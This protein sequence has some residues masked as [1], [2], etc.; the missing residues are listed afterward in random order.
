[1]AMEFSPPE[2]YKILVMAAPTGHLTLARAIISYLEDLPGVQIHTIDLV[3]GNFEWK[4]FRF[5][6]RYTP[7]MMGLFFMIG[8]V[9]PILGLIAANNKK[10]MKEKIRQILVDEDPDLVITTY[11]GYT[12]IL[13]EIR[14]QFR[15]KYINPVSDPVSLHPILY[16]PGADVNVGFDENAI[17]YGIKLGIQKERLAAAGWFTHRVF[18]EP[19]PVAQIRQKLGL[20]EKLT[21]LVCAGSEGSHAM[22]ALL[23]VLFVKH[24]P[25]PFQL[26]FITG[27]DQ[28]L[29][30]QI[31]AFYR[32]AARINPQLPRTVIHTYTERMQEFLA[33]SDL[34]IGKAGPNFI[35]ECVA[36]GKPFMAITHI[37]GNESGNLALIEDNHLGW[38]A[39]NPLKASKIISQVIENPSLLHEKSLALERMKE[40]CAAGNLYIRQQVCEWIGWQETV[41]FNDKTISSPR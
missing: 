1:M 6:Y 26:V 17:T 40:R 10:R 16:A 4:I 5:F 25:R 29:A 23:P 27:T 28:V 37:S 14:G 15:F 7:F 3:A 19:Q 20:D 30:R 38:S 41:Y 22:L 36:Q 33:V 11:H 13:D 12:P 2:L 8:L 18:F 39:E 24:H 35:F 21:L 9:K 31:Q 32:R 34:V